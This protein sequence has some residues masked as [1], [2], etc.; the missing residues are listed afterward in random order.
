MN[1]KTKKMSKT[2]KP[3]GRPKVKDERK[4]KVN[5]RLNDKEMKEIRRYL[6]KNKIDQ[7]SPFI[8]K[9]ILAHV[10]QLDIFDK[11]LEA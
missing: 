3:M 8:R 4:H 2:R 11:S 5:V 1:T 9:L 7:L 10:R 6:K